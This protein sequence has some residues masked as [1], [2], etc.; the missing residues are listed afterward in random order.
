MNNFPTPENFEQQDSDPQIIL[1]EDQEFLDEHDDHFFEQQHQEPFDFNE[2]LALKCDE[3]Q[4]SWIGTTLKQ[5]IDDEYEKRSKWLSIIRKSLEALGL[6]D[7]YNVVDNKSAIK[8][9]AFSEAWQ[10]LIAEYTDQLFNPMNIVKADIKNRSFIGMMP[11]LA[12]QMDVFEK[13]VQATEEDFNYKIFR[14]WKE[15]L[16]VLKK[17]MSSSFL[18][19][20]A[21][22]KTYYDP[23]LERPVIRMIEPEDILI[24]AEADSLE[25]ADFIGHIFTMTQKEY[26]SKVDDGVYRDANIN[27]TGDN[28]YAGESVKNKRDQISGQDHTMDEDKDYQKTMFAEAIVDFSPDD[29][30]DNY[31]ELFH[32]HKKKFPYKVQFH[33]E[34]GKVIDARRGWYE[35][36][37]SIVKKTNM[38]H[39][40]FLQAFDFW[41]A[42]LAQLSYGLS[43]VA[44]VLENEL[45]TSIRLVNK[46]SGLISSSVGLPNNTENIE[47]G[48]LSNIST[49]SGNVT[50]SVRMFQFPQPMPIFKELLDK[51]EQKIKTSVSIAKLKVDTLPPNLAGTVLLSLLSKETRMMSGAMKGYIASMDELFGLIQEILVNEMG[52]AN[53]SAM[54]MGV[55]NSEMYG[56]PIVI[57]SGADPNF[58]D[59]ASQFVRMQ[60]VMEMAEKAPQVHNMREL[61]HRLYTILKEPNIDGILL[62]EQQIQEQQQ[63]QQQ[64]QQQEM[65]LQQQQAQAQQQQQEMQNKLL[66]ADVEQKA[67]ASELKAQTDATKLSTNVEI[68]KLKVGMQKLI[69][70]NEV[71]KNINQQHAEVYQATLRFVVEK[72]KLK[73]ETGITAPNLPEPEMIPFHDLNLE[74]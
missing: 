31:P 43:E 69:A 16:F 72:L 33:L 1:P 17:A 45:I 8:N 38:V 53:F 44:T 54:E 11:Q 36:R 30:A 63:Q 48:K 18:T 62:T 12:P 13:K 22:I 41:G 19:G 7:S 35:G 9:S 42:G 32:T 60:V 58:S 49:D 26:E 57:K 52:D 34:T 55:K 5:R 28:D 2:N 64:Q 68:E 65:Q 27:F 23:E 56:F 21:V 29:I 61:Y 50:D 73:A 15:F 39:F 66:M 6:N 71:I 74:L 37:K 14:E 25:T 51:I 70:E 20:G 67:K 4:L 3:S 47:A 40:R 46:P 10:E 59:S 24:P